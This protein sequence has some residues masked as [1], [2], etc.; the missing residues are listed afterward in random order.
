MFFVEKQRVYAAGVRH[1]DIDKELPCIVSSEATYY[2]KASPRLAI[3][4]PGPLL[5]EDSRKSF[6]PK[7]GNPKSAA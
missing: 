1:F 4:N 2:A 7:F 5:Y 6:S 3:S